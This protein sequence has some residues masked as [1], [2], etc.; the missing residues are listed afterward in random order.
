M[1]KSRTV[2]AVVAVALVVFGWAGPARADGPYNPVANRGGDL[3]LDAQKD[4]TGWPTWNGDRVQLWGCNYQQHQRWFWQALD[5]D[6][7]DTW[8]Q[9]VNGYGLCL[10]AKNDTVR[11]PNEDG[12]PV[13]LWNC[14]Q[15]PWQQWKWNGN[16][17]IQNRFGLRKCLDARDDANGNPRQNGDKVQ[18]WTCS[19]GPNQ[20]WY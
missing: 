3:C 16:G 13:Q 9:V 1:R 4:S 19:G 12:D 7:Q 8:F 5:F 17:T 20:T 6:G 18:L 15:A 11:T 10:D 2:V 14:T